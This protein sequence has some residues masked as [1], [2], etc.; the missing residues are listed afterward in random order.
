M[1]SGLVWNL[2]TCNRSLYSSFLHNSCKIYTDSCFSQFHMNRPTSQEYNWEQILPGHVSGL[3]VV[4]DSFNDPSPSSTQ[5]SPR[6]PGRGLV[7]DLVSCSTPPPQVTVQ[8]PSVAHSVQPPGRSV[9]ERK[10]S[11]KQNYVDTEQMKACD[12][13]L[14]LLVHPDHPEM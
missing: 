1:I 11:L 5:W 4:A 12:L 7:Q 9:E 8:P 3:Q 6:G 14:L 10:M 13:P 2:S